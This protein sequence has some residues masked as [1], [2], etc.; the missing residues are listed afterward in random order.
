M[1]DDFP[2]SATS[3]VCRLTS[4]IAYVRKRLCIRKF[5]SNRLVTRKFEELTQ[6]GEE[7]LSL[8]IEYDR[9]KM[10]EAVDRAEERLHK[11]I[12]QDQMK[13]K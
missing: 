11:A 13:G 2:N 7:L 12:K 10:R 4:E 6:L 9:D 5:S 1:S 8:A 3:V